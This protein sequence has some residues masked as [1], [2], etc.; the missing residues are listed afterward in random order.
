MLFFMVVAAQLVLGYEVVWCGGVCSY[1]F[2]TF[3]SKSCPHCQSLHSFFSTNFQGMYVFVW[4]ESTAAGLNLLY[5]IATAEVKYGLSSS[6]AGATPHTLVFSD[7]V[8]V[9]VVIGAV[10]NSEFW[11]SLLKLNTTEFVPVYLGTTV[12][13]KIPRTSLTNLLTE[14]DKLLNPA[15]TTT[16]PNTTA[17]PTT[18]TE[19]IATTQTNTT[20]P[21]A[22][23]SKNLTNTYLASAAATAVMTAILL[24]LL[25]QRLRHSP[26]S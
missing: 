3:G 2:V 9:A 6:Y 23:T 14:L 22:G 26:R 1:S 10:E 8:L 5:D 15:D 19:A 13:A 7:C 20:T 25:R 17:T 18:N 21:D 24:I 11:S 4:I 16:E 12:R